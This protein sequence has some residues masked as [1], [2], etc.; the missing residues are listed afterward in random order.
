MEKSKLQNFTY[1]VI[2]SVEVLYAHWYNLKNNYSID[3]SENFR[4]AFFP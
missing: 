4:Q 3:Q 2:E 1:T